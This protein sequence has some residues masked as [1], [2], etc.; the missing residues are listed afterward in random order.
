MK[1]M[2]DTNVIVSAVL[3]PNSSL[4]QLLAKITNE[5]TLVICS[6]TVDELQRIFKK[7]F[8]E[9]LNAL[10]EFLLKLTFEFFYTPQHIEPTHYPVIRDNADLPILVSS[11]LAEVDILVTGDKDFADV[12]IE[13]PEILTPREFMEN[14]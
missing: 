13:K 7:K 11:I 9:M 2:V 8:P 12:K 3:F 4:T 6:H 14:H 1:I 10:E 5:H